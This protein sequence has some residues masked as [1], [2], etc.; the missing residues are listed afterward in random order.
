MVAGDENNRRVGEGLTQPLELPE[1][2]DD[3]VIGGA[4]GV[5]EVPSEDHSVRP[6]GDDAVDGGT[7]GL[8]D[9]CLPLV[10]ATRGLPVVLP[11][12]EMRI[13]DMSQFHG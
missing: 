1:R 13:G 9:V 7:K 3:G 8:G 10:D 11:D 6:A 5:K 2:K 4:H 12:S